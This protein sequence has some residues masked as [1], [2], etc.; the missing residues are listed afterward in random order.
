MFLDVDGKQ[1]EM[2]MTECQLAVSSKGVM[3][4]GSTVYF[5]QTINMHIIPEGSGALSSPV[6]FQHIKMLATRRWSHG[7]N[8]QKIH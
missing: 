8:C 4:T 5:I 7:I 3:A 6:C 2:E 1:I